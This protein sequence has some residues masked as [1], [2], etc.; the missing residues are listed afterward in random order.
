MLHY[1]QLPAEGELTTPEDPPPSWPE[2]GEIKFDNV[3]MAY[4]AGLPTVLKGIS[5]DI[6]AGEKVRLGSALFLIDTHHVFSKQVGVVGRTGAGKSSLL[7]AIFR[8][9]WSS[10]SKNIELIA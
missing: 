10:S 1:T 4:R 3:E 9:V 5:F 2:Q 8:Y 7:Q 6:R